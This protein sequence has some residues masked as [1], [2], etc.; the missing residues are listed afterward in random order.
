MK[1]FKEYLEEETLNETGLEVLAFGLA[2]A[3]IGGSLAAGKSIER[4]GWKKWMADRKKDKR[5]IEILNKV[6]K[7]KDII[8]AVKD[9]V[10]KT[11]RETVREILRKMLSSDEQ[12]YLFF[13]LNSLVGSLGVKQVSL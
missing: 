2:G 8:K 7:N 11:Q 5:G 4:G 6:K 12:E 13:I 1:T 3:L 9:G 10:S